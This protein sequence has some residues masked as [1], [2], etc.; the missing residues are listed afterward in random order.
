[1]GGYLCY[2]VFPREAPVFSREAKPLTPDMVKELKSHHVSDKRILDLIEQH[3]INF[4]EIEDISPLLSELKSLGVAE[5]MINIVRQKW[6]TEQAENRRIEEKLKE[7][8]GSP[9]KTA[10]SLKQAQSQLKK[11]DQN[12]RISQQKLF[13]M[14]GIT[15]VNALVYDSKAEDLI[16]VG[17]NNAKQLPLTLD[18]LVVILQSRFNYGKYPVVTVNPVQGTKQSGSLPVLYD[19]GIEDTQLG[20]DM[21]EAYDLLRKISLNLVSSGVAGFKTYWDLAK[22]QVR[23]EAKPMKIQSRFWLCPKNA[24]LVI[25]QNVVAIRQPEVVCLTEV[26]AVEWNGRLVKDIDKFEDPIGDEFARQIS[27]RYKELAQH[28]YPLGRLQSLTQLVALSRAIEDA[29]FTPDLSYWLKGY[30]VAKVSTPKYAKVLR[31]KA[32]TLSITVGSHWL[33]E[34]EEISSFGYS[35]E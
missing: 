8:I 13:T 14:G 12:W 32:D 19:A 22:E 23:K 25:G 29:D 31:R 18:D 21:F 4:G 16:I 26:I 35:D 30:K 33:L 2:P 7:I 27:R 20:K 10:F 34:H 11:V 28:H 15:E 5:S 9:S 24:S 1:M 3:G 6:A 17:T